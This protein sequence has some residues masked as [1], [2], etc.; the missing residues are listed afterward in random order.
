MATAAPEFDSAPEVRVSRFQSAGLEAAME[1]FAN[2]QAL[3][4]GMVCVIDLDAV[5]QRFGSRWPMRREHVHEHVNSTLDRQLGPTAYHL[6]ISDTDVLICQPDKERLAGQALCLR[7]LREILTHFLGDGEM[8][9]VGVH[10]VVRISPEGGVEARRVDVRAAAADAAERAG[11]TGGAP[12]PDSPSSL[13]GANQWT[14]FVTAYGVGLQVTTRLE[15]VLQLRERR[16]IGLRLTNCVAHVRSGRQLRAPELARLTT[17]DLLRIDVAGLLK[18]L[19]A[20]R[21]EGERRL[22]VIVPVTLS[23]LSHPAGR[24][25]IIT[26]LQEAR[27]HVDGGVICELRLIEGAP[28][29]A[30]T[31]A[32]AIVRP[33]CLLVVGNLD[34]P[35][36]G[37]TRLLK[38]TGLNCV[39]TRVP[40]GLEGAAFI[41]WASA[42]IRSARHASKSALLYGLASEHAMSTAMVLGAT[43]GSRA[44]WSVAA[45]APPGATASSRPGAQ[46]RL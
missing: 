46:H 36:I 14:P 22:T 21:Q 35:N 4:A 3:A 16:D 9:D 43:H 17:A 20:L 7:A 33:Y 18:G 2:P 27:E 29:A 28:S 5:V 8:A 1:Q 24:A 13:G 6:R 19:E 41:G 44:D 15:P 40:Q 10:E 38:G 45:Q 26:G 34:E 25:R 42:A 12:Q 32:V 31:Q 11:M 39:A 37:L 23:S 30:L